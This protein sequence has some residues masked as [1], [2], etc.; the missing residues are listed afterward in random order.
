ML[1]LS[2]TAPFSKHPRVNFT[3]I[4]RKNVSFNTIFYNIII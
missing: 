2:Y 3:E 4:S 1:F